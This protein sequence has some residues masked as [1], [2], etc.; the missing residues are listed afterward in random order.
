MNIEKVIDQF[1]QYVQEAKVQYIFK[2]N[3]YLN[4]L[5]LEYK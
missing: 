5:P 1:Y 4:R 2:T 3:V